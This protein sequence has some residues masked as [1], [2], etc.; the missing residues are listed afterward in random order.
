MGG[1]DLPLVWSIGNEPDMEWTGT[2]AAL[3]AYVADYTKTIAVAMRDVDSSISI[4]SSD[5][6]FYSTAKF[7]ALLGGGEAQDG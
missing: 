5:M 1:G 3:A 2:E 7:E 4:S 6:A